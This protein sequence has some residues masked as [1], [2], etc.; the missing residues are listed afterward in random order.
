MA[1]V[2]TNIITIIDVT[3]IRPIIT[4]IISP[5]TITVGII[6]VIMIIGAQMIS[7]LAAKLGP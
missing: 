4:I 3:T 1:T 6:G 7:F 5:I 2:R